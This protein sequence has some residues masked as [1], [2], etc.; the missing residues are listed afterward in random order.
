MNIYSDE[1]LT[2]LGIISGTTSK[3]FGN[4]RE[5]ENRNKFFERL[6]V[7][8]ARMLAVKQ[9][10]GTDIVEINTEEDF[11]KALNNE[12][13]ADAWVV[14]L[15]GAGA[16]I[17]T[18]DCVPLFIWDKN[19]VAVGLAHCGWRGVVGGLPAALARAVRKYSP[20]QLEAFIG[21]HISKCCF[22]V[23]D[24]VLKHFSKSSIV[25][26]DG[27]TFVDLDAEIKKQLKKE[28]VK[29]KDIKVPCSCMCTCCNEK[30]FFS[31]RRTK[32]KEVMLSFVYKV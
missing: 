2:A 21:P 3:P 23:K 30:E 11:N 15:K 13:S 19:G 8:A 26:K 31:Y 22:E 16:A 5:I 1:R 29:T 10:H 17:G 25:E 9:V 20:G 27:K 28:G 18:A 12:L 14:T 6:S 4:L 32:S 24:D 7:P